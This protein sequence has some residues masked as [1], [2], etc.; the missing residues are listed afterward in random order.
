MS[1]AKK[2]FRNFLRAFSYLTDIVTVPSGL[3]FK[4]TYKKVNTLTEKEI[5]SVA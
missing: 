4:L 2:A 3:A 5:K 1:K